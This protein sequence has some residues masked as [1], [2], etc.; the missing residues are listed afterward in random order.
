MLPLLR[1]LGIGFVPYSPLGRG[2]LTGTL[3]RATLNRE[4]DFRRFLPRFSEELF[5][6]NLAQTQ[7]LV[8][9]AVEKGVTPAQMALAWLLAKGDDIVPI[10]GTRQLSRLSENIAAVNVALSMDEIKFLEKAFAPGSIRG[11]RY[12]AQGMAGIDK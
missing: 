5:E 9:L 6:A 7:A 12:T 1:E 10:P 2:A 11:E 8:R 4:G 3:D